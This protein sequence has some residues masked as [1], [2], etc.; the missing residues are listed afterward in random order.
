MRIE[1]LKNQT[2]II[3]GNAFK[4]E[5]INKIG[6]GLP[7]VNIRNID[8]KSQKWFYSGAYTSKYLVKNGDLLVSLNKKT[9]KCVIWNNGQ[10]LI[11]RGVFKVTPSTAQLT[12]LYLFHFLTYELSRK[13]K[14]D[15]KESLNLMTIQTLQELNIPIPDSNTEQKHIAKILLDAYDLVTQKKQSI[16]LL[17]ELLKSTFLKLF[18]NPVTNP[19]GWNIVSL[20][21]LAFIQRGRTITKQSQDNGILFP[22]LNTKH[23]QWFKLNLEALEEMSFPEIEQHQFLLK[24]GDVILCGSGEIGKA[25]IWKNEIDE[26]FF[27]ENLYRLRPNDT[28]IT[29]EYLVYFFWFLALQQRFKS[30]STVNNINKTSYLAENK[31]K[32][33]KIPLPPLKLQKEFVGK[34][35]S[36]ELIEQDFNKS[37]LELYSFYFTLCH[38]AF[39]GQLDLNRVGSK[40][41]YVKS[42]TQDI[43]SESDSP[44]E[45]GHLVP[46]KRKEK[47]ETQWQ[48]ILKEYY[49]KTSQ[50]IQ[51]LSKKEEKRLAKDKTFYQ[52]ILKEVFRK[53]TLSFEEFKKNLAIIVREETGTYV[54][55]KYELWRKYFF[56]FISSKPAILEQIFDKQENTIK[57][58]LTDEAFKA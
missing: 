46:V 57:F 37:L 20:E 44:F 34:L 14:T 58:R 10:A 50:K 42:T 43:V 27:Q 13:D 45:L 11:N 1:K 29:P 33:L 56:K 9:S 7:L 32:R 26:C 41:F 28:L 35:E 23:V 30:I 18:N 12:R 21:K 2:T 6:E 8:T 51:N 38:K 19:K 17:D 16:R 55:I 40:Y 22:C 31:F 54:G 24:N 36:I 48:R 4:P 52:V 53:N 39:T 25:A 3:L 47:E 49:R 15:E 5:F